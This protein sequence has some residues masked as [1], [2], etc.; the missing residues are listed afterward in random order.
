MPAIAPKL[1]EVFAVLNPDLSVNTVPVTP[2]IYTDL[3]TNFNHFKG[4][5]LISEYAFTTDWP[6]WERHPAGD[7][8]VVLLAGRVEMV[9]RTADGDEIICLDQPGKYVVVPAG[10]WHTARTSVPTR[11][12]F[13]T[14]GE[15]TENRAEP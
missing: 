7:E 8:L 1:A 3:D 9:L 12:L 2:S 11:M 5:V 10:T 4:R 14:P 15:G 13:V 6:T